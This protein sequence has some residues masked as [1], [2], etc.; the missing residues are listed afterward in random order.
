MPGR[1]ED[2]VVHR[3]LVS[4]KGAK[5]VWGAVGACNCPCSCPASVVFGQLPAI[6]CPARHE[7]LR[8]VHE[9]VGE[10]S[11]HRD[12]GRPIAPVSQV[13]PRGTR[14]A[15]RAVALAEARRALW[16]QGQI[17]QLVTAPAVWGVGVQARFQQPPRALL[18]MVVWACGNLVNTSVTSV[19]TSADCASGRGLRARTATLAELPIVCTPMRGGMV[20]GVA[21]WAQLGLP[22]C[23][24]WAE[25]SPREGDVCLPR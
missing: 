9:P 5:R 10:R 25:P 7:H 17:T 24:R 11:G 13:P 16:A 20:V 22:W 18:G 15:W 1:L 6:G 19:D 2:A 4:K 3:R 21:P 23:G 12:C 14:V 8:R